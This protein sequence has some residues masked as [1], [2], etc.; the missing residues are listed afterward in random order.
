M[1]KSIKPYFLFSTGSI[2]LALILS[3]IFSFSLQNTWQAGV[4]LPFIFGPYWI[5]GYKVSKDIKQNHPFL[6]FIIRFYLFLFV[7]SFVTI[8]IVYFFIH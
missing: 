6:F 3:K 2:I 4:V 7:I 5:W 1:S 8:Y